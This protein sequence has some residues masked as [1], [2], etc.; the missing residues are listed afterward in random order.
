MDEYA[1]RLCTC[2]CPTSFFRFPFSLFLSSRSVHL[3]PILPPCT[4]WWGAKDMCASQGAPRWGRVPDKVTATKCWFLFLSLFPL[5]LLLRSC[6]FPLP[7]PA[8]LFPSFITV[9]SFSF[10]FPPHLLE[11]LLSLSLSLSLSIFP[12]WQP[13][14]GMCSVIERTIQNNNKLS[15]PLP[16][17]FH[18]LPPSS[19]SCNLH[20]LG[21]MRR[22]T[23]REE[24]K[25]FHCERRAKSLFRPFLHSAIFLRPLSAILSVLP[26]LA[27]SQSERVCA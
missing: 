12:T 2:I 19:A 15:S 13:S 6:S 5:F 18:L 26:H 17:T 1:R 16:L 22:V 14:W 9:P 8:Y 21:P 27:M 23:L 20:G 10:S 11:P 7:P 3:P 4:V 25:D 24:M